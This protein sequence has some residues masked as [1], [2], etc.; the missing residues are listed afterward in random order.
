MICSLIFLGFVCLLEGFVV[1]V[2]GGGGGGVI[3]GGG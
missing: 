1:M 2:G 3:L